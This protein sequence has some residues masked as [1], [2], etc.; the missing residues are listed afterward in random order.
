MNIAD[1]ILE[2]RKRKASD[3]TILAQIIKQ[4]PE[5]AEVFTEAR[6]R[7]ANATLI[8]NEMIK[9]NSYK[10]NPKLRADD[11]SAKR[12]GAINPYDS[13]EP[14][15][16]VFGSNEEGA[17]MLSIAGDA[18]L[19]GLKTGITKAAPNLLSS[20]WGMAKNVGNAIAHPIDTLGAVGGVALGAA[21]K[22][23]PGRQDA[24]DN[25]DAFAATLKERYGSLENLA[26]TATND[27]FVF[28]SEIVGAAKL[29]ANA[30]G[31]GAQFDNAVAKTG[32]LVTKPAGALIGKTRKLATDTLGWTTGAGKEATNQAFTNPKSIQKGISGGTTPEEVVAKTNDALETVRNNMRSD[33]KL[34]MTKIKKMTVQMPEKFVAVKESLLKQLDD[35]G[36]KVDPKV[37]GGLD[38]SKSA[39]GNK[40]EAM[41]DV[42]GVFK[43]VMSWDDFSPIG[44]DTLKRRLG[45]LYSE[46]G[47][48]RAIVASTK[49]QVTKILDSVPGY[50]EMTSGYAKT[51]ALLDQLKSISPAKIETAFT[52]LSQALKK[53]DNI[54]LALIKE[55]EA[56]SGTDIIGD[57]AGIN[58][59]PNIST[60]LTGKLAT[61]GM[62]VAVLSNP[63]LI[64]QFL[65]TALVTSPKAV[66][67][68]LQALGVSNNTIKQVFKI[69]NEVS[70]SSGITGGATMALPVLNATQR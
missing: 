24:E 20:A 17:G 35:F 11:V 42:R 8:L 4:N 46:T 9:Q 28:G 47:N 44:L 52:K 40:A 39:I 12:Y 51:S 55:L 66:G 64:A 18:A 63:T 23:I 67:K 57:I 2:A 68:F 19:T 34:E 45:D 69:A 15:V 38:F 54:R 1:S 21:E 30:T 53:N 59:Q 41:A 13:Q 27:P 31:Y 32:Q 3:D 26:R 16:N 61:G 6:N 7:G 48:A 65:G 10:K 50:T 33:Y 25:F 60:G 62:G 58:L 37:K 70:Y 29:G 49:T 56:A 36:V 5:K 43:D 14:G 22:L